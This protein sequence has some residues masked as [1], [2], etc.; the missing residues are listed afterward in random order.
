MWPTGGGLIWRE[1]ETEVVALFGGFF[2]FRFEGTDLFQASGIWPKNTWPA[3]TFAP[4]VFLS[5]LSCACFASFWCLLLEVLHHIEI[6]RR[7]DRPPAV[8]LLWLLLVA[9]IAR[10]RRRSP[11][12]ASS[13]NGKRKQ[14]KHLCTC[15]LFRSAGTLRALYTWRPPHALWGLASIVPAPPWTRTACLAPTRAPD[16]AS[17]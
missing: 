6:D 5:F 8:C 7:L 11:P 1:R 9:S 14:K 3:R 15:C 13:T 2:N 4:F 17:N 10:D 16:R 12:R